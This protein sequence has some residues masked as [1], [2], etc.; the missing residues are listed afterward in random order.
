MQIRYHD[1]A[2][3]GVQDVVEHEVETVERRLEDVA[4]DL[5]LLDVTVEHYERSDTYTARLVL[6]IPNRTIAARRDGGKTAS[7]AVRKAFDDLRDQLDEHLAKLRGEKQIRDEQR[8]PA[9]QAPP[10]VPE[11]E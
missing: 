11:T 8:K 10:G 9:W 7:E 4:D 2:V 3:T 1:L 6:Q 5:K